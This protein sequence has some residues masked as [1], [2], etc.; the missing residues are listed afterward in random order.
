M[1]P[2]EDRSGG[3]KESAR[4]HRYRNNA[5]RKFDNEKN[6]DEKIL[7]NKE[8]LQWN[9]MAPPNRLPYNKYYDEKMLSIGC[10]E[11]EAIQ[12]NTECVVKLFKYLKNTTTRPLSLYFD[13]SVSNMGRMIKQYNLYVDS[14]DS[15][16]KDLIIPT[17]AH[18]LM[19]FFKVGIDN[20]IKL[21]KVFIKVMGLRG[22]IYQG[23]EIDIIYNDIYKAL[24]TSG[25]ILHNLMGMEKDDVKETLTQMK[26]E[27]YFKL[28]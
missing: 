8:W 25:A 14:Y 26:I 21:A 23:K 19:L 28:N 20:E 1:F 4:K 12:Y 7:L 11:D 6:K 27:K 16:N 18:F 17:V 9:L 24:I 22:V 10:I 13:Y 3:F 2:N 15:D 5:K